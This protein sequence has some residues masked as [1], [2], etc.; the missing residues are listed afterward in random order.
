MNSYMMKI[1][2]KV[3]A[4]LSLFFMILCLSIGF[5]AFNTTLTING[6][7]AVSKSSWDVHFTNLRDKVTTGE[8]TEITAPTLQKTSI[9]N[10]AV[11]LRKPKDSIT[12]Q[13][14]VENTGTYNAK[15]TSVNI[16]KLTCT[17]NGSNAD[18]DAANVCKYITYTLKYSDGTDVKVN[19]TL[20]SGVKKTMIL[21]LTYGDDNVTKDELAKSDVT[22][23]N[24]QITLAYSQL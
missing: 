5:A 8:A 19:D 20:N 15:I 2:K 1:N 17:G 22:L 11:S 12:Y 18:N 14:D 24:F 23:S 3:I 4:I 16:P 7:G 10:F 9:A 13:F 6:T 21:K